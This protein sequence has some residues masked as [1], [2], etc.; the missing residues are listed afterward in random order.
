MA[1]GV[2]GN[3]RSSCWGGERRQTGLGSVEMQ[4]LE[5]TAD[6]IRLR[7]VYHILDAL[8]IGLSVD[9]EPQQIGDCLFRN[10]TARLQVLKRLRDLLKRAGKLIFDGI[11]VVPDEVLQAIRLSFGLGVVPDGGQLLLG[12]LIGTGNRPCDRLP[13]LALPLERRC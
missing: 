5:K 12:R 6:L 7:G 13:V 9:D 8:D 2:D 1:A 3:L 11:E 10:S 4:T